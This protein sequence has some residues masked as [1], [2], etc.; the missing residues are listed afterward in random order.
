VFALAGMLAGNGSVLQKRRALELERRQRESHFRHLREVLD[1]SGEKGC[2][3]NPSRTCTRRRTQCPSGSSRAGIPRSLYPVRYRESAFRRC[4]G[5]ASR[6]NQVT[7]TA[8]HWIDG[9]W[10]ASESGATAQS[11]NP[12]T[13]EPLGELADAGT[14]EA[15]AAIAAAPR[16]FDDGTWARQPRVRAHVLLALAD[17]MEAVKPELAWDLARENGKPIRDAM[18]EVGGAVSE[19]R[20]YAGLARNIF[21]RTIELEPNL[22]T[23]LRREPVGVVA[24]IVPSIRRASG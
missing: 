1:P 16:V 21:G 8:K 4:H 13:G 2:S 22:H 15:E 18:Q 17:R 12:G 3:H 14:A 7:Q 19:L 11:L 24:I 10:R 6:R 5:A 9:E 23:L 20:Y